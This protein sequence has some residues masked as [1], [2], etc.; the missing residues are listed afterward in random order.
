MKLMHVFNESSGNS[1]E[2]Y[3]CMFTEMMLKDL[4]RF[5]KSNTTMILVGIGREMMQNSHFFGT[6]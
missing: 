2:T 3:H 1:K 6:I 5:L 4:L